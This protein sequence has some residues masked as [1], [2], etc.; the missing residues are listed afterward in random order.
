MT[1]CI[2]LTDF[3]AQAITR[4]AGP[5]RLATELRQNGF[6]VR[7]IEHTTRW[8]LAQL[9][10]LVYKHIDRD[11]LFVGVST[12]FFT[13]TVD[14]DTDNPT[15]D[16]TA[17]EFIREIKRRNPNTKMVLGGA[18]ATR[19]TSPLIDYFVMGHADYAL[20]QLARYLN[21]DSAELETRPAGGGRYVI[22]ATKSYVVE[23]FNHGI[24]FTHEDYLR[25]DEP[26]PIEFARGCIFKCA[27]CSY[28]L[29]GKRRDQYVR[30][31]G[32]IRDEIWRNYDMFG[33]TDYIIMDDTINDTA[34]KVADLHAA[35]TSLPFEVKFTGYLRL[36]LLYR[37]KDTATLLREMGMESAFFGIESLHEETARKIGKGGNIKRMKEAMHWIRGTWGD[38]VLTKGSFIVGFPSEPITSILDTYKWG[39]SPDFPL[40]S[41][42]WTPLTVS[43]TVHNG[44]ASVDVVFSSRMQQEPEKFDLTNLVDG[45]WQGTMT[46]EQKT[47]LTD[48]WREEV[49]H[50]KVYAGLLYHTRRNC[51]DGKPKFFHESEG[52]MRSKQYRREV[53]K[54]RQAYIQSVLR[55]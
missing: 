10:A 8:T 13:K 23:E 7:V 4:P 48:R 21:G 6:S 2:I 38:D 12:T 5:Y 22:D 47:A 39:M 16:N 55:E 41:I 27:F 43:N 46:H 36:D 28:P 45:R 40:H 11:T 34:E 51:I 18:F 42:N 30:D 24:E 52:S 50:R 15:I 35:I 37:F 3:S 54:R 32:S 17:T 29:N 53:V 31:T 9:K 20:V 14:W 1:Q 26:L 44:N 25:P 49:A 33:T 19:H